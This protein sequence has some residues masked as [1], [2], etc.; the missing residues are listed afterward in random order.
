M[1][2]VTYQAA[3]PGLGRLSDW[4]EE[5]GLVEIRVARGTEAR[6]FIPSLNATLRDFMSK[7]QWYQLWDGEIISAASPENPMCVTFEVSRLRPAPLVEIR[8]HKGH[9]ALHV[10]P[11]AKVEEIVQAL[12]PSI[13]EFL[14]GGQWFQVWHGEIV[15]M[16]SPGIAAA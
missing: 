8:E 4:R 10:S 16:E 9:V 11:T 6:Q 1:L 14:A 5:R 12:N 3:D 7:A 2:R 13:E 15:T